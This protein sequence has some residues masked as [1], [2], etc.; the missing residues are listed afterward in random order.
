M[1]KVI[2][3]TYQPHGH[4]NTSMPLSTLNL[5][6][7]LTT[8]SIPALDIMV[9]ICFPCTNYRYINNISCALISYI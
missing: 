8:N 6:C 3:T 9:C 4:I 7:L 5:Q 2:S 1:S